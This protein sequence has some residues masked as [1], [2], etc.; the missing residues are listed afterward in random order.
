MADG[1][2]LESD[3]ADVAEYERDEPEEGGSFDA[4]RG[5]QSTTF[6]MP[7]M[8]QVQR[9]DPNQPKVRTGYTQQQQSDLA[10]LNSMMGVVDKMHATGELHDKAYAYAVQDLFK[11]QQGIRPVALQLPQTDEGPQIKTVGGRDFVKEGRGWRE[12]ASVKKDKPE[13]DFVTPQQL[14]SASRQH[15]AAEQ[16]AWNLN[17]DNDGKPFPSWSEDRH[18]QYQAQTY[19]RMLMAYQLIKNPALAQQQL[20]QAQQNIQ[21]QSAA[22][23][24]PQMQQ[25]SGL[26]NAL[27]QQPQQQPM[28][29]PTQATQQAIQ[30][31][32][33]Q[34]L[35]PDQAA[36][37]DAGAVFRGVD[38]KKYRRK[39]P[40][41]PGQ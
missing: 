34:V 16:K 10:K 36:H 3:P 5:S 27:M 35:P 18:A 32:Q 4:P 13:K 6:N 41:Q 14:E 7:D 17:A 29:Q 15:E 23:R 33:P 30:Q 37:L 26:G 28:P 1:D 12:L 8:S 40:Q 2:F 25:A 19:Q 20:Q 24:I 11:R 38:G 21:Q 22:S 39:P 9:Q 31:S